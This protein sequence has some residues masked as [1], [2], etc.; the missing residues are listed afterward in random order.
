VTNETHLVCFLECGQCTLDSVRMR[1]RQKLSP[2]GAIPVTR[3]EE[4]KLRLSIEKFA[5]TVVSAAS[6]L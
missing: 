6:L 3:R 5:L 2:A 1:S 4:P